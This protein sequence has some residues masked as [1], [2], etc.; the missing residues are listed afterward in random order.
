MRTITISAALSVGLMAGQA[1]ADQLQWVG[2]YGKATADDII[3]GGIDA[4]HAYPIP[5]RV[6]RAMV[7][8]VGDKYPGAVVSS[9]CT[10]NFGGV[11]FP[12][13][14]YEVLVPGQKSA[15]TGTIPTNATNK[16]AHGARLGVPLYFCRA[17]LGGGKGVQLGSLATGSS[18]CL[19]PYRGTTQTVSSYEVLVDKDPRLPLTTA[20]VSGGGD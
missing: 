18:G 7:T 8:A 3:V 15:S 4:N 13:S 10:V 11:A 14:S 2:Q 17:D 16:G 6:C 9:G 1:M 20:N 12:S 5:I 19:I